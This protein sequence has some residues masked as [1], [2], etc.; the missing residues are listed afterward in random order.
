MT[1]RSIILR[2]APFA[3]LPCLLSCDNSR[4]SSPVYLGVAISPRPASVQTGNTVI[5]TGTVSNNLSIPQWSILDSANSANP[6]TLTPVSGAPNEI[7]YTA[8]ATPP[9]YSTPNAVTQGTVT[10]QANVTDP[11]GTSIPTTSDSVSFVVTAPAVS[12]S[13]TPLTASVPLGGAQ[14]FIGYAVGNVNNALTWQIN[15]VAGG[16]TSTGTITTGG[17]YTA[18][19][20]MPMNGSSVTLTIVSQADTT[21]SESAVITLH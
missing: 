18:P 11:A 9:I 13:L 21:K 6:G 3:L 10:L 12:L 15:G 17:L 1:L 19:A 5:F 2:S 16:S 20:T 8:P 14:Q 7:L 4:V